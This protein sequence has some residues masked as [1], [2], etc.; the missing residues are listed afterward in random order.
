L[1]STPIAG[2]PSNT[3]QHFGS[4]QRPDTTFEP[5]MIDGGLPSFFTNNPWL[6]VLSKRGRPEDPP[7]AG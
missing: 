2:S 6:D 4:F 7:L 5:G 1:S 3:A